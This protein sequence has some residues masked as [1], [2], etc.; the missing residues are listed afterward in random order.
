MRASLQRIGNSVGV[1]IPKPLLALLGFEREVDI[2]MVDQHLEIRAVRR[3]PREGWA[4]TLAAIPD[5]E[6]ELTQEDRDFLDADLTSD[7]DEL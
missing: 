2:E 7:V 3:K 1:I 4:E 5:S 6:L